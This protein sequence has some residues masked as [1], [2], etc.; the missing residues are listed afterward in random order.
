MKRLNVDFRKL[1]DGEYGIEEQVIILQWI[2]KTAAP[3]SAYTSRWGKDGIDKL[4]FGYSANDHVTYGDIGGTNWADIHRKLEIIFYRVVV[5][6]TTNPITQWR[7]D[8]NIFLGKRKF[9]PIEDYNFGGT[10]DFYAKMVELKKLEGRIFKKHKFPKRHTWAN[11]HKYSVANIRYSVGPK[12]AVIKFDA[13]KDGHTR[14]NHYTIKP[15][16]S[17][18]DHL[19]RVIDNITKRVYKV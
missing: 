17:V 6:S 4:I 9:L 3:Y 5:K 19:C 13:K 14:D 16:E 7:I 12:G 2:Y 1:V 15:M 10:M 18:Y 11:N 8:Y